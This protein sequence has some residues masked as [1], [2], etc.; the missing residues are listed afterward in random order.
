MGCY[1]DEIFRYNVDDI[2]E[3]FL[4][5]DADRL[6]CVGQSTLKIL[7]NGD[8]LDPHNYK[9]RL[10]L[11]RA[12]LLSLIEDAITSGDA[13]EAY[14]SRFVICARIIMG[15]RYFDDMIFVL[16]GLANKDDWSDRDFFFYTESLLVVR[17]VSVLAHMKAISLDKGKPHTGK[18]DSLYSI[19]LSLPESILLRRLKALKKQHDESLPAVRQK[20]N[21]S[22]YPKIPNY[23]RCFDLREAGLTYEEVGR[24]VYQPHPDRCDSATDSAK[25]GYSRAKDI[26]RNLLPGDAIVAVHLDGT[27]CLEKVNEN[28]SAFRGASSL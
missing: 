9:R 16:I 28:I 2:I 25:K 15:F 27:S 20:I 10:A 24:E 18:N 17:T 6:R 3:G 1:D 21:P 11:A 7:F 23:I 4:D 5:G 12:A 8:V 26:L 19:D 22:W 13:A 14:S